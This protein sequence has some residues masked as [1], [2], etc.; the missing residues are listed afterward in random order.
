MHFKMGSNTFLGFF[1]ISI[2]LPNNMFK[3]FCHFN[4]YNCLI[5]RYVLKNAPSE[6]ISAQY[7]SCLI[8]NLFVNQRWVPCTEEARFKFWWLFSFQHFGCRCRINLV[9]LNLKFSLSDKE[10]HIIVLFTYLLLSY[11]KFEWAEN[12]A[13]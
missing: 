6:R 11:R 1:F 10:V 3:Q 2:H 13:V 7:T 12:P 5:N 9:T 8:I 4:F